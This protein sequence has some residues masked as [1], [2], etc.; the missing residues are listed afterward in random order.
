MHTVELHGKL[1]SSARKGAA[2]Q[3]RAAGKIPGILY[4]AGEDP[5]AISV[6]VHD[7]DKILRTEGSGAFIIDLKLDGQEGKDLK[8]I[9]KEL[10]RDPVTSRV[11]HMDLQHVSMSQ[12]IH[13]HVPIHL[14]GTPIGVKEG[15]ILEHI[16]R[17]IEVQCR[18]DQIPERI[19]MDVSGLAKHHSLHV[20]DLPIPEMITVLTPTDRV[21]ATI[22]AKVTEVVHEVPAVAPAAVEGEQKEAGKDKEKAE[23]ARAGS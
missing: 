17:D 18:A 23:E 16:Q 8:A 3:L 15:G 1:R 13:V 21:V 12:R 10:Q 11:I 5:V 20:S 9:I 2:R 22:L 7:L 19:D 6:E 4:G 14:V